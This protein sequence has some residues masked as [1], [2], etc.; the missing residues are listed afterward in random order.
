MPNHSVQKVAR[1]KYGHISAKKHRLW[2]DT[3]VFVLVGNG[4]TAEEADEFIS[5]C[6]QILDSPASSRDDRGCDNTN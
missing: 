5:R 4:H 1:L 2:V 6:L 3:I